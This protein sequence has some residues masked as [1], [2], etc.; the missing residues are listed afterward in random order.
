MGRPLKLT[1]ETSIE[2]RLEHR[3]NCSYSR[4]HAPKGCAVRRNRGE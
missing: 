4:A 1:V 2:T 3:R